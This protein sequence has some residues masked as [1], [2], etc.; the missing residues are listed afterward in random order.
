MNRVFLAIEQIASP[1]RRHHKQRETLIGLGLNR[2]GRVVELPD[3]PT[4]RGMIRKVRH[5]VRVV[6][7]ATELGLFVDAVRAIYR[8]LVTTRIVR[9]NVLWAQFEEAVAACRAVS[10]YV[11]AALYPCA[12]SRCSEQRLQDAA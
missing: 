11:R 7:L 9:G 5:L 2:I 3:S 1:I 4:T 6:R 10:A 12:R 8:D